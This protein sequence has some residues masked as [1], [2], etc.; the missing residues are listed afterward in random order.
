MTDPARPSPTPAPDAP[1]RDAVL[2]RLAGLGLRLP[3][4]AA[5]AYSYDPVVAWGDVAF[6]SGQVSRREGRV[7]DGVL[8]VDRSLEQ[9]V[10]AA[11]VCALNAL[12]HLDATVGLDRVARVLKLMVFVASAPDVIEQ[13]RAAEGASQVLRA[14]LGDAGRHARTALGVPRLPVDALVEIDLVVGLRPA[15]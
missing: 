11:E 9:A 4:I 13:P 6:V 12:A 1:G 5:P 15:D 8:G 10:E 3:A 2:A 14:A 7:Y